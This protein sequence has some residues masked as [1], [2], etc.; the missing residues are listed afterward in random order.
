MSCSRWGGH[1]KKM[2]GLQDKTAD[3]CGGRRSKED[4]EE[5][6][7]LTSLSK[8]RTQGVA[9]VRVGGSGRG[10]TGIKAIEQRPNVCLRSGVR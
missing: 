7:V 9:A 5:A 3:A 10:E 4:E 1:E 8:R 2:S 6:E